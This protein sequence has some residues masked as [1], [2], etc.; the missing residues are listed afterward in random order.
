MKYIKVKVLVDTDESREW[1][2]TADEWAQTP[3][4][5]LATRFAIISTNFTAVY[6]DIDKRVT[7]VNYSD[8]ESYLVVMQYDEFITMLTTLNEITV[9][10]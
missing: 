7:C 6:P 8:A 5:M 10:N 2:K 1:K 3:R 4:N 9:L